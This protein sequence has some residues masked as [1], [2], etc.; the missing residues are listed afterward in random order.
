MHCF[1]CYFR[2][3]KLFMKAERQSSWLSQISIET[4]MDTAVC[5]KLA[6]SISFQSEGESCPLDEHDLPSR[7]LQMPPE[8]IIKGP[9]FSEN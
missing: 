9:T 5:L 8:V 7:L 2:F 6:S 1:I 4:K 3:L